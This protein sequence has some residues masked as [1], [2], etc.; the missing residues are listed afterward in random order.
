M[1]HIPLWPTVY[2]FYYFLYHRLAALVFSR[3][4]LEMTSHPLFKKIEKKSCTLNSFFG[5]FHDERDKVKINKY[6]Y[7]HCKL[8]A[9]TQT[10]LYVLGK[11]IFILLANLLS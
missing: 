8:I 10:V 4:T 5:Q 9:L 11:N 3:P 6:V 1:Y 2:N 7:F